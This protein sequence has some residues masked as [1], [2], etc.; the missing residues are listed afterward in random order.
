M[1]SVSDWNAAMGEPDFGGP[2]FPPGADSDVKRRAFLRE[3]RPKTE[4]PYRA[5][6]ERTQMHDHCA[7]CAVGE[8]E[9]G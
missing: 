1:P 5:Y 8:C 7:E 6:R 3:L 2:L 4:L 9:G